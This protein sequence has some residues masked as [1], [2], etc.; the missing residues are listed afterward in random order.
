[1]NDQLWI[2][3]VPINNIYR[4]CIKEK[5]PKTIAEIPD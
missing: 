2:Q 3:I 5:R 4:I 1:M